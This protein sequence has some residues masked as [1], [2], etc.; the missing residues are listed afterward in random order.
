M[1]DRKAG[2]HPAHLDAAGIAIAAQARVAVID[3]IKFS[4]SLP[5]SHAGITVNTLWGDLAVQ[6]LGAEG[7][8]LLAEADQAGTSP[9]KEALTTLLQRAAPC[10][11][12]LDELVAYVRQLEP[13]KSYPGGTFDS[14]ITFIQALT[15]AMKG[16]PNAILLASLP[17]SE[18][19]ARRHP[20]PARP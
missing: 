1:P 13:G 17:E 12:L 16:V 5:R 9:G 15:E 18:T 19:E 3:G 6:L 2:G 7:Y 20:R 4:P 14:N 10:V 11:V 8:A